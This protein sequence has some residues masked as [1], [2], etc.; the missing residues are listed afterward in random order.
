MEEIASRSFPGIPA[1]VRAAARSEP[2]EGHGVGFL[3]RA[4]SGTFVAGDCVARYE[5]TKAT[6]SST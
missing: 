3:Q 5:V 6:I 1:V 4:A 2:A